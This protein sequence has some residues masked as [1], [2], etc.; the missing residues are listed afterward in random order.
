MN[1]F[2]R[3]SNKHYKAVRSAY[4]WTLNRLQMELRGCTQCLRRTF[5]DCEQNRKVVNISERRKSINR[6]L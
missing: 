3:I 6:E 4:G 1:V 2:E 5:T